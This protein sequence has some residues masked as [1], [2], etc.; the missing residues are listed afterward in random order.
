MTI[1]LPELARKIPE[2]DRTALQVNKLLPALKILKIHLF[3]V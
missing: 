3:Q 1:E 2:A